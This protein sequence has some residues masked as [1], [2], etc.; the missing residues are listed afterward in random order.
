LQ[1]S[2]INVTG[3]RSNPNRALNWRGFGTKLDKPAYGAIATKTR[4]GGGH[5]GFVAGIT[6]NGGIVLL[7]GNQSDSVN[8]TV[9]SPGTV[10]QY[11]YPNGFTPN[12]N[13]PTLNIRAGSIKEN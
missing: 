7:G 9:Y 8:Y 1:N 6:S 5:V 3:V 10:F 4:R 11:N 12:Y 2:N 13:L